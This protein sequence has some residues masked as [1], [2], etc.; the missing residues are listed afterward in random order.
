MFGLTKRPK[1]FLKFE[2]KNIEKEIDRSKRFGYSFGILTVEVPHSVPRGLSSILPGKTLSFH[3]MEKN[4]RRYD[5]I[6]QS[7]QRI[8]Y[9]ILPQ[10]DKNGVEIVINRIRKMASNHGWDNISISSAV[11]PE[12]GATAVKLLEKFSGT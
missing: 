5:T 9:I 8:Y 10:T 6:M 1:K 2:S 7:L 3:V 12:D 11:Y 4:I